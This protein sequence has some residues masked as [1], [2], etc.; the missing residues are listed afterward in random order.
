MLRPWT[1]H[2]GQANVGPSP[3]SACLNAAPPAIVAAAV[4]PLEGHA[5]TSGRLALQSGLAVVTAV[6]LVAGLLA[7]AFVRPATDDP[8]RAA[9]A[10][11]VEMSPDTVPGPGATPLE[12][13]LP[14]LLRFVQQARGLTYDHPVKVTLLDDA[15]FRK[16]LLGEELQQTKASAKAMA[17]TGRVLQGLGLL[18]RDVDLQRAT[19]SLYGAAVAGFYDTERKDL[20]VRG[21]RLTP[22]VRATLVHELTHALQAQHFDIERKDLKGR[23]DESTDGLQG[24]VEGDAVRI[25][26]LYEATFTPEERKAGELESL[27]A[28]AGIDPETPRVLLQLIGFPYVVGPTF[29]SEVVA[30]GGQARLDQAFAEPPVSTEELFH[31]DRYV[32]GDAVVPVAVE[33]PALPAK[34]KAIDHGVFG[35]LLLLLVLNT[36]GTS[37]QKAAEGWGGGRYVAWREGRDTCVRVRVAM[38][39][40]ADTT[41]LRQALAGLQRVRKRLTVT[42][43]AEGPLTFTSCA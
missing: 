18:D 23:D 20:V 34:V 28:G 37:G 10:R 3:C 26:R 2:C 27:A 25:Q 11:T 36:S 6:L 22:S 17:T 15:A 5:P 16:R 8:S 42:G 40:P 7:A 29:T 41:E 30:R 32:S 43:P 9:A 35:E 19:R 14:G 38:D 39:G 4:L 21:Q 1:C 31:P 24:V 13:A 33:A 12:Q